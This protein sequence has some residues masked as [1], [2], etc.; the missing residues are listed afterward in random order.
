MQ[1]KKQQK[2]GKRQEWKDQMKESDRMLK[3]NVLLEKPQ[4]VLMLT[5]AAE[6]LLLVVL[7]VLV[8][9]F[10]RF[11]KGHLT[12]CFSWSCLTTFYPALAPVYIFLV[13]VAI[14]VAILNVYRFRNAFR[15]LEAGQ[16]GTSRF[17]TMEE[18]KEQ[19]PAVSEIPQKNEDGSIKRIPGNGGLPVAS[20]D[21]YMYLD[22]SATNALILAITRAGK[23]EVFSLRMLDSYSRSEKQPSLIILDMKF[24]LR[25]M[26]TKAFQDRG[27]EVMSINLENPMRG[28]GYN[29]LYLITR[30]YQQGRDSDAELLCKAFAYPHFASAGGKS[31]DNSDFFLSNATS[32]LVATIMAHTVD[33]LRQDKRENAKLAMQYLTKRQA[34]EQLTEEEKKKANQ[35]YEEL[36]KEKTFVQCVLEAKVIPD[37]VP[38][39]VQETNARKNNMASVMNMFTNLAGET[40]GKNKT[41][42]DEY[43]DLRGRFDRARAVY[44]SINVSG[45]KTKGSI[46]SQML[47]K[48]SQYT[49]GGMEQLTRESTFS[50]EELG[51]G[52]KPIALF[53]QVPFYDRSKDAIAIS[54]IDQLYQANARACVQSPSGKCDRRIIFH[55]DEVAQFPPIENLDSKLSICLGLNMAFNLIIQT[56]AQLT[57]KYGEAAKIIKGNCGNQVYLQTSEEETAK[58]FSSL[59]GSKTITNVNRVGTR[60]ALNKSYTETLEERPLLNPRELMDL[61]EGENVVLRTMYRRDMQGNKIKPRPIFNSRKEGRAFLYRYQYLQEYFPDA[62]TVSE[63]SLHLPTLK[64]VRADEMMYDYDIS[65]E[66]AKFAQL[67]KQMEEIQDEIKRMEDGGALEE[68]IEDLDEVYRQM[69]EEKEKLAKKQLYQWDTPMAQS[70]DEEMATHEKQLLQFCEKLGEYDIEI[71]KLLNQTCTAGELLVQVT[72]STSIPFKEKYNLLLQ[73]KGKLGL[74]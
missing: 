17:T 70:E 48:L 8:N 36:R 14:A 46:F 60:F 5:L 19:Y 15:S 43:F 30:Y 74:A 63:E 40:A 31:D 18:I 28:V 10:I 2:Q 64:A 16:K 29:P 68:D 37:D 3:G 4:W 39:E 33:C 34:Y 73:L 50:P 44:S 51:F 38:F 53:L 26:C 42:L 20:K 12:D 9:T 32:A 58:L 71:F 27:Y 49:F 7:H 45:D 65:F 23:G 24:D 47:T 6:F 57:L 59:L 55:L 56:D 25:K 35:S 41:K 62:D 66:A 52:K 1:Q 69:E 61:E 54:M 22:E 21:G 11:C 13:I 72:N 67:P